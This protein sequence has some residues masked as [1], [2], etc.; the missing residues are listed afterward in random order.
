MNLPQFSIRRPVTTLMLCLIAILLGAIAFIRIP[1]DLMPEVIYPTLSVSATYPGVAPEEMENLVTRP[2]EEAFAAAPG[3]E[4]ITS[5]SME[6]QSFIRVSFSFGTNLDEAANELRSRL[7][8]R[9]ATL[10]EDMDPPVIFKFDVSQFPIMFLSVA[11]SDMDPKQLRHFVE[12]QVRYRLERVPGVAQFT[13]RGG[14]RREIHVKLDLKKLRALELSVARVVEIIRQENLNRPVGPV[15]EGRFEVLLRTQG[16]FDN[17]EQ[18]RNLVVTTRNGIPIHLRDVAV[19]EDAHEEE[20]Y[21]VSVDGQPAVRLFVYKQSGANTVRVSEGVWKEIDQIHRDYPNVRITATMDSA[22][23]I[24]ASVRNVQ[25]AASLG[26]LLAVAVLLFFLRSLASTVIIGVAIPIAV[27]STFALMYFNGFTLNVVSFGALALGVGMLVDNSIVVLENIFRHRQEGKSAREAAIHGSREVATAITASTLTTVA[28]FV[29]VLFLS[30]MSAQTFKQLAWVVSFALLC[31]LIVALT[32]VPMLCSRFLPRFDKD[33]GR[34]L[35]GVFGR[36]SAAFVEGITQAYSRALGWAVAH[37]KSILA[38]G[39]ATMLLTLYLWPKI[40]V[41]LTPEVDEGEIRITVELEPGTHVDAT[42]AVMERIAAIARQEVPEAR[43]IMVESGATSPF[44]GGGGQ[45]TGELRISLVP[46]SERDRSVQQILA[47]LRPR[48]QVEPGMIVRARLG[49][50]M[51]SRVTRTGVAEGDR[52]SVEIRGHELEVLDQLARQVRQAMVAVPGVVETQI[53][54]QPGLPEMLVLVDRPKAASMGLNVYDV[55]E[56]LETAIGG[57][58][59]SMYRQEG[60]EYNILVRLQEEDRLDLAKVGQIP[61]ATPVGRTIPAESIVRLRRQEGPIAITRADQQRIV[62]VSGTIAGRDLG[63]IVRDLEPALRQIPKPAGYEITFG[64]EYEEQQK[65]FRELTFAAI[66]ALILV[67]MVMASQFESLRDPF[68]I[69]FSIPLAGIGVAGLLLL[70]GTTFNIQGFLGLIVLVG[71][72]VNN[73]IVLIDYTNLL[74][75]EHG[76]GVREAVLTAGRRRLRPILMTT[77]TTVLGLVPM[78]LGIGEGAELQAP[79]ARVVIGGLLTSTLITLVFIPVVYMLL[80]ERT[81]RVAVR[82]VAR[83]PE[84]L[85]AP[86]D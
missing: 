78:A 30:G 81:E 23:F 19:V 72:V 56:T 66:L 27:I 24:K 46:R 53:S 17:L 20:R 39:G 35:F 33:A 32:V 34:G 11:A 37:P 16:E 28:V 52:L 79:L 31:S 38:F 43:H 55:A 21:K 18:I 70:T 80:E 51:V 67:Y 48:L 61:I 82:D 84:P 22:E 83:A 40:G 3:V 44:R 9:R 58:R 15:R 86:G 75:R 6:G 2:L 36:L 14:L 85:P 68:I 60:D 45:H 10:P 4:E 50:G 26:A 25:N 12:K 76:M 49:G 63:S 29:P 57:R 59:A 69:L 5:V 47:A 8:R 77:A 54:R 65:A 73:A 41:E 71:I 64:G 74:R 42:H 62:T 1:V 13:V 7:D